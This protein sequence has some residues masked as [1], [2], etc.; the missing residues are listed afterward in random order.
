MSD[1]MEMDVA[2]TKWAQTD[3]P[4]RTPL[5]ERIQDRQATFRDDGD[6][7]D[8]RGYIVDDAQLAEVAALD[9]ERAM[10]C[11]HAQ[12]M[13]VHS[14]DFLGDDPGEIGTS[15]CGE[16]ERFAALEQA[17]ESHVAI[18]KHKNELL[19][20]LERERDDARWA[21][22]T[23][24]EQSEQSGAEVERLRAAIRGMEC[25]CLP[26]AKPY[27]G[28]CERCMALTKPEGER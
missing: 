9:Q 3:A 14:S 7:R 26:H 6:V 18:I 25:T 4:E 20:A 12:R 27:D 1:E 17:D 23:W 5:S 8:R 24:R 21:K 16:C 19:D 2:K 11:G 13:A 10:P 22:R 28:M 15:Y